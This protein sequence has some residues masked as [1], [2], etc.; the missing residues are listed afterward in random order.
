METIGEYFKAKLGVDLQDD[1]GQCLECPLESAVGDDAVKVIDIAA[2]V[3]SGGNMIDSAALVEH[4]R[5]VIGEFV[6]R[7]TGPVSLA[8]EVCLVLMYG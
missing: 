3:L 5:G 2:R 1:Q 7:H 8:N 6:N 4:S